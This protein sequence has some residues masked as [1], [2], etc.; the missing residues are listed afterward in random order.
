M[1]SIEELFGKMDPTFHSLVRNILVPDPNIRSSASV[2]L[3]HQYLS[4]RGPTLPRG[5]NRSVRREGGT[6]P[7]EQPAGRSMNGRKGSL[8]PDQSRNG[9]RGE[10]VKVA[11]NDSPMSPRKPRKTK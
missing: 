3:K 6:K 4:E 5:M 10:E 9:G 1:R 7:R 11:G 2:L 8:P